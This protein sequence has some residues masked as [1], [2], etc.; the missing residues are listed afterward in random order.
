MSNSSPTT[1]RRL[2]DSVAAASPTA[3][4][5]AIKE[6]NVEEE[7][8]KRALRGET[9]MIG[10]GDYKYAIARWMKEGA[11]IGRVVVQVGGSVGVMAGLI[12]GGCCSNVGLQDLFGLLGMTSVEGFC[13][14]RY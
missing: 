6:I 14:D 13:S 4:G 5:L 11:R 3:N 10:G 2:A 8:R 9:G 1:R 12:F 7:A